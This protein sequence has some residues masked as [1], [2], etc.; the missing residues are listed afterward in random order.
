MSGFFESVF[1]IFASAAAQGVTQ[2]P[3]LLI[4]QGHATIVTKFFFHESAS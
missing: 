3:A 1:A 4:N 2:K